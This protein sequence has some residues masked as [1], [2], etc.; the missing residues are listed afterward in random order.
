MTFYLET[1][2]VRGRV[3]IVGELEIIISAPYA[4]RN[5]IDRPLMT[6]CQH[7]LKKYGRLNIKKVL[8]NH[9]Q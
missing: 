9:D 1:S 4:L 2:K 3:T 5:F 7:L 6:L 8:E